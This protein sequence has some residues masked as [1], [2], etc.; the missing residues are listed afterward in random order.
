[1]KYLRC[2]KVSYVKKVGS[3]LGRKGYSRS[4]WIRLHSP[5]IPVICFTGNPLAKAETIQALK[6]ELEEANKLLKTFR[7]KG[8]TEDGIECLSPSAA[9]AS[10]LLKSGVTLTGIYSQMVSPISK[11]GTSFFFGSWGSVTFWC[12]FGSGSADPDS[13]TTLR[14]L[15]SYFFLYN[16]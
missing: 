14:M 11:F 7:D 5:N 15:S 1:L 12:R 6:K 8:L 3:G 2:V 4:A 16:L 10:R 9:Q 13:S